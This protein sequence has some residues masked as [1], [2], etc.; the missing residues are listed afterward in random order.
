MRSFYAKLN[1]AKVGFGLA[2]I[3]ILYLMMRVVL[4]LDIEGSPFP[5]FDEWWFLKDTSFL[6]TVL[7]MNNENFQFFTNAFLWLAPRLGIPF[8][9]GRYFSLA[10]L[11][12]MMW[13]LYNRL[14]SHVAQSR[15]FMLVLAFCPFFWSYMASNLLWTNLSQ[16][17]MYFL[18][19][20]LSIKFGFEKPQKTRYQFLTLGLILAAFVAMNISLPIIFAVLYLARALY[21]HRRISMREFAL[22]CFCSSVI[23]MTACL[24]YVW[25]RRHDMTEFSFATLLTPE[26]WLWLSYGLFGVWSGFLVSA[27]QAW[28]Y[29]IGGGMA[30]I[31]LGFLFFRQ[32]QKPQKQ[33]MWVIAIILIGGM[34]MIT[35]FRGESI[36]LIAGYAGRHIPYGICLI[37]VIYALGASDKNKI[38]RYISDG[39]LVVMLVCS[40]G[41][42]NTEKIRDKFVHV[43]NGTVCFMYHLQ[44]ERNTQPFACGLG[45]ED[46]REPFR[47][48]VTHDAA[49]RPFYDNAI[50][51][52]LTKDADRFA[53]VYRVPGKR[54]FLKKIYALMPF[55]GQY[56]QMSKE[57]S[58]GDWVKLINR[59]FA[60]SYQPL[61]K[62]FKLEITGR[63]NG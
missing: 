25:I 4:F 13:V 45:W 16:A 22:S 43:R 6:T 46:V 41:H 60:I 44:L 50:F 62:E 30:V 56:N 39:I 33:A 21:F 31:W 15:R 32:I 23:L 54:L 17:W 10:L 47:Y 61:V 53:M 58:G 2:L 27:E 24:F 9:L 11:L 52:G 37:P 49:F 3:P 35:L 55:Y 7:A 19:M 38:V 28:F 48:F 42:Y 57:F 5:Q 36:L 51:F 20:F 63:E 26:Y 12:L 59:I 29:Y 1:W 18:L 14:K 40:L 34:A 8:F